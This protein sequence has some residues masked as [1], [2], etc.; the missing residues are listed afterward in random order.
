MAWG[1][2]KGNKATLHMDS[3]GL[4][5]KEL[6]LNFDTSSSRLKICFDFI[7]KS[8]CILPIFFLKKI[9]SMAN[10]SSFLFI[11]NFIILKQSLHLTEGDLLALLLCHGNMSADGR[12]AQ[13]LIWGS[14]S[15]LEHG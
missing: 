12:R 3:F 11:L 2:H 13:G 10:F 4:D 6:N 1:I 15:G 5:L 8:C 9:V 7:S 14:S